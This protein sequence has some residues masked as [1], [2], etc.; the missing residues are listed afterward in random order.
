[1]QD[2]KP[3]VM[4]ALSRVGITGLRTLVKINWSGRDYKFVPEIE[5]TMDL[6]KEKRGVHMSRLV[7]SITESIEEEAEVK[8][9]SLEELN[10]HILER[11]RNKHPYRTAEILMNAELVV[12]KKTPVTGKN[13]METHDVFVSV[14]ADNGR[15]KKKLKVKVIG[16]S[17]CPHALKKSDGISHV[18]RA[19]CFLEVAT[20]Y[21]NQVVLEDMIDCVERAF[22]SEVYT[23]LKVEDEKHVVE[24]MF[25]RPRFVEDITRDVLNNAKK[26]FKGCEIRVKTVSEESIHRHDVVAE[27]FCRS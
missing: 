13:T 21:E 1:M 15:F 9:K 12:D 4:E 20:G 16:N 10:R 2:S 24:K 14:I 3:E 22:P 23:L 11:V 17:V 5:L 19:V 18:Q 27:G 6:P 8:H 26:R 25:Q 7:E